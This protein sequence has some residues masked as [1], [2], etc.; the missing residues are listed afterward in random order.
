MSLQARPVLFPFFGNLSR[1]LI[2]ANFRVFI[3]NSADMPPITIA[4]WYGGHADVPILIIASYRK[5]LKA[6]GLRTDFVFW[7]RK[8]L[9]ADPPPFWIKANLYSFPVVE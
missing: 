9:F 3:L 2:E 6:F 5:D 1:Y 8:D 4:K 7:Y